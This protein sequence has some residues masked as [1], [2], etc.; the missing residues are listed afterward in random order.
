M[1]AVPAVV[2]AYEAFVSAAVV[3]SAGAAVVLPESDFEDPHALKDAAS[4]TASV[5]AN[6]LFFIIRNSSY[7]L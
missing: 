4:R 2:S 3:V 7:H 1:T 6:A 5:T